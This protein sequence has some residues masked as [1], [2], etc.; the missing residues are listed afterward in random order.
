MPANAVSL[1]PV[2]R[3]V[4]ETVRQLKGRSKVIQLSRHARRA[5]AISAQKSGLR[6][7][8]PQKDDDGVPVPL[9]GVYW[10]LTHKSRFVGAVVASTAVGID[11][12]EIKEVSPAMFRRIADEAEWSL[13]G[14]KSRVDFFR[15]WT[16]KEAV[17]K[18]VGMGMKGLSRCRIQRIA[19]DR[20]LVLAYMGKSFLVEQIQ[21]HDHLAAV[22]T[23]GCRVEWSIEYGD[24]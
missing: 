13:S 2:I 8:K 16:A 21:F 17:L 12:E 22:V 1:Y 5:L 23:D 10:S 6:F 14:R 19:D 20:H 4:P 3:K 24:G 18:A 7:G 9:D 15:F 11:L